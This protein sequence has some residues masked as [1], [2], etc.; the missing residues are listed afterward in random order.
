[1]V[2]NVQNSFA[3]VKC[4]SDFPVRNVSRGVS[5]KFLLMQY[6]LNKTKPDTCISWSAVVDTYQRVVR[7]CHIIQWRYNLLQIITSEQETNEHQPPTQ[8]VKLDRIQNS[9]LETKV[10]TEAEV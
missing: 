3:A 10:I 4:L 9:L 5:Y 8:I 2:M 7:R 1:M 6:I